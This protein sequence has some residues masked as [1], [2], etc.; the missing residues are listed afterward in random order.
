MYSI[1]DLISERPSQR[2]GLDRLGQR[3]QRDD[4]LSRETWLSRQRINPGDLWNGHSRHFAPGQAGKGLI[5][6]GVVLGMPFLTLSSANI[7]FA[8]KK[9]VWGTYTAA[10]ALPSWSKCQFG[11]EEVRFLG[12][13]VSSQGVLTY[14]C[15]LGLPT[16]IDVGL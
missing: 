13:V 14:R 8:E 4:R 1:S 15:S 12:Y 2:T 16:S 3:G 7:R 5:L 9:L 6:L 11:Q 10:E